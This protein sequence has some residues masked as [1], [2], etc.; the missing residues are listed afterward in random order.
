MLCL[1]VRLAAFYG[2]AL[3]NCLL[4]LGRGDEFGN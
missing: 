3:A 1:I 2:S 4:K